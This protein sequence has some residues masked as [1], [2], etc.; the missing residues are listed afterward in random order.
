MKQTFVGVK[1]PS[2][3]LSTPPTHCARC[4][5][6]RWMH[7]ERPRLGFELIRVYCSF[8]NREALL[9]Y[10]GRKWRDKKGG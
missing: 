10:K 6:M 8:M 1:C 7:V 9:E 2:T 4:S 5:A 3:G